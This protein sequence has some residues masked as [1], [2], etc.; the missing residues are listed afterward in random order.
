MSEKAEICSPAEAAWRAFK[1]ADRLSARVDLAIPILFFGDL[2]RYLA[3]ALRVLTV[4]LNPS[5]QEF[6]EDSPF[7]RFPYAKGAVL[8]GLDNYLKALSAYFRTDP[9]STW[10]NAFEHLLGGLGA[11]YYNG[12]PS[13][14]LHTDICSPVAI[15]PTW[16]DLGHITQNI[17]EEDG[18]PLW[19][20]LMSVLRPTS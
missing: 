9:Y 2:D 15:D 19:H 11:S 8:D 18:G 17:L 12:K 14:A 13:T 16:S 3:S 6:P 7:R 10:F 20:D 1:R 4:G 5:L